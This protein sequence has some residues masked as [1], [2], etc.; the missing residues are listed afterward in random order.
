MSTPSNA[1]REA[2]AVATRKD[3]KLTVERRSNRAS[4]VAERLFFGSP[5]LKS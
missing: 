2:Y 1:R 3:R 4:K 5:A